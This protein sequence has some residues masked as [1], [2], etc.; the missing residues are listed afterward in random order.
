[1]R[2]ARVVMH[3]DLDY[4][5]AQCEEREN[6]I[7]AGRPV[8]VCVYSGR[9]GDSGAVSTANYVARQYGVKS[10][11]PIM[12][13]KR[14]LKDEEAVFLP[15][16]HEFYEA[17]S[18]KTMDML[19]RYAS[20]FEQ[21]G[22][23]E[24]FLDVSDQVGG[25][26]E[27]ARELAKEIKRSVLAEE[28]LTCSIGVGPNKLVAKMASGFQKPDGLTV[29]KPGEV[30]HFLSDMPIGKLYGVGRK[31]EKVMRK[32]GIKT[33]GELS[34]HDVRKLVEVFGKTL[35]NYFHHASL[36]VDESPVQERGR[37]QSISRIVTLKQNTRDLNIILEEVYPLC[38]DVHSRAVEQGLSFR[39]ISTIAVM[40]DLSIRT[41]SKTLESPTSE[42]DV[43]RRTAKELFEQLLDEEQ[44]LEV[45]RAGVKVSSL[46]QFQKRQ[47]YLTDFVGQA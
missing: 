5:F 10:G 46:A 38:D 15:V 3:V 37:A 22:I 29:V 21:V 39:S 36:G 16:R 13:A 27:R 33:I 18:R 1:M 14:I 40:R 47:T 17:V 32:L 25:D 42:L 2:S 26:F 24:V 28:K 8:V 11:I 7:L 44:E 4:F 6:P 19:R 9:G 35:G 41:R 34:R 23:D 12:R 45:R 31:T 20:R 30:E 43:I